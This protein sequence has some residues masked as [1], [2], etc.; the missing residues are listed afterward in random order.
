MTELFVENIFIANLFKVTWNF[1]FS[2]P[3]F[4][5]N[6]IIVIGIRPKLKIQF[7]HEWFYRNTFQIRYPEN[8]HKFKSPRHAAQSTGVSDAKDL[9]A[10]LSETVVLKIF[11]EKSLINQIFT[12]FRSKP[13]KSHQYRRFFQNFI[14]NLI[15]FV[16]LKI[17]IL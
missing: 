14:K 7:F 5:Q 8:I 6:S 10:A 15:D 2:W 16:N 3:K 13:S 4:W 17:W 9:Q 12:I 1:D 11:F